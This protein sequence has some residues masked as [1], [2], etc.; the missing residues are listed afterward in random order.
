MEQSARAQV[1][2][3]DGPGGSTSAPSLLQNVRACSSL[4]NASPWVS[5]VVWL[6]VWDVLH[7]AIRR[8]T[9]SNPRA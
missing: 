9:D 8:S 4:S 2:H 1:L 7:V 5:D 6:I 3:Q